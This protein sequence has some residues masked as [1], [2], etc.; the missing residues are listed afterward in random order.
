MLMVDTN[1]WIP[2]DE[3]TAADWRG[4]D[5]K[6]RLWAID[7]DYEFPGWS[8]WDEAARPYLETFLWVHTPWSED[9]LSRTGRAAF[10]E[11]GLRH[12]FAELQYRGLGWLRPEGVRRE[13]LKMAAGWQG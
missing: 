6:L 11:D 13:L 12:L 1:P 10:K 9:G 8:D 4:E 7:W 5:Q 2:R 3:R